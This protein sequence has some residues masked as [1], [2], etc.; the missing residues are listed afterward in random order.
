MTHGEDLLWYGKTNSH[1]LQPSIQHM[2]SPQGSVY[3][4]TR[5]NNELPFTFA[6]CGRSKRI[7]DVSPVGVLW[8]L[9]PVP[10]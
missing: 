4:F 7:D 5:S 8:E 2:I 9:S 10:L 6:G 1:K 3:I